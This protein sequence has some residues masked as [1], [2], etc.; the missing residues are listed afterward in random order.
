MY[1]TFNKIIF[2]P[3]R[4]SFCAIGTRNNGH[5]VAINYLTQTAQKLKSTLQCWIANILGHGWF[6]TNTLYASCQTGGLLYPLAH[7]RV[8][9]ECKLSF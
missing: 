1:S 5:V 4:M 6:F 2:F 8:N 9:P 7:I 3:F